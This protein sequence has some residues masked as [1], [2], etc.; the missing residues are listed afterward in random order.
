VTLLPDDNRPTPAGVPG[1]ARRAFRRFAPLAL[2]VVLIALAYGLGLHRDL[3][4]ETLIRNHA[5]IDRFIAQHG[6]AA[7]AAYIVIY[8]VVIGLSLPGGAILTVV[9]GFLFGP[10]LGSAAAVVGAIAGAIVIF[11]IARSAVGEALTRR[12]GPFAARL[13]EG[14]RADAFNYLLFLRLV[15]FP[16]WLVNLASALF[17]VRLSTFVAATAIGILPAT[18]TFAVFGAGLDSVIAAQEAQYHVCMEARRTDCSVD[19]ELSN[20]LTPTLLGALAALGVLA[21]VPVF[22]RRLWGRKLGVGVPSN[23]P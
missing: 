22:A 18:V 12:A 11:L 17:G 3:S 2:V 4:F 10:V 14:F 8:I 1:R 20:V 19:F 6:I 5:A 13:A 15:P 21:L 7:V 16:F 23:K 9:G